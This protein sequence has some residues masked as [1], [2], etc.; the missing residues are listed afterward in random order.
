M[1]RST[2]VQEIDIPETARSQSL[3]RNAQL[4]RLIGGQALGQGG[5]GLLQVS[6]AQIVVFE[7]GKGATPS[8]VAKILAA[9]LLPYSLAGPVAGTAI[10][11]V[12]RRR[13]LT[14]TALARACL[15]VAALW[16][17][18]SRSQ[19]LGYLVLIA[20]LSTSRLVLAAKGAAIPNVAPP[21][22]LA[23]ANS[24][25]GIA[26]LLAAF[27]GALVGA[28]LA[29]ISTQIGLLA[30]G[31]VY[32]L[33]AVCFRGLGY[34]GG[35]RESVHSTSERA[36]RLR[37]ALRE[38]L[39]A[40]SDP[41]VG[42]ALAAIFANRFTMGAGLVIAVLVADKRYGLQAPGYALALVVTGVG[43][44][45]GTAASPAL[46]GK[47]S[48]WG[49][50][51][52]S[53]ATTAAAAAFAATTRIELLSTALF[54]AVAAFAFQVMK[55]RIDVHL[56][57]VAPDLVRGRVFSLYDVS[58]NLAFVIAALALALVWQ[59]ERENSLLWGVAAL[60]TTFALVAGSFSPLR[61]PLLKALAS[62]IAGSLPLLAF[63]EPSLWPI[64]WISL[65][66]SMVVVASSS[67]AKEAVW[68]SVWAGAGFFLA[69]HHWL[70]PKVGFFMAFI[71]ML[72]GAM[73]IPNGVTWWWARKKVRTTAGRVLVAGL[74]VPSV[75]TLLEF[76]R[77]WDRLGGAWGLMGATQWNS[78]PFL[79][80]A[81]LGGVWLL[82]FVVVAVNALVATSLLA[83]QGRAAGR[84]APLGVAAATAGA[85]AILGA[86]AGAQPQHADPMPTAP[87][88]IRVVGVQ[89]GHIEDGLE[90]FRA[91]EAI[92]LSLPS[93][94]PE[95]VDHTG[96]DAR[97]HARPDLI[98]W[99]ES[100][101][102]FDP[103][104]EPAFVE[105]VRQAA[106]ANGA[107]VLINV[108][109]R[110]GDTGG[111]Y[112]TA[113]VVTPEGPTS[114]YDKMRL[115]PFGEYVPLRPLLG[116][117]SRLTDAADE[118]R[119][120]GSSLQILEV[121][122]PK[123]EIRVGALVCFESSFPDMTRNLARSGAQLIVVQSATTTFQN[124][125][126]PEQHASLAA[127]RAAETG[128]PVVHATLSGHSAIYDSRGKPLV[129]LE[130]DR[131]GAYQATVILP[132]PSSRD[133]HATLYVRW[134]DWVV[135]VAVVV[136]AVWAAV[137]LRSRQPVKYAR[138]KEIYGA[139]PD[140]D[141]DGYV[142]RRG[143]IEERP[144]VR[145]GSEAPERHSVAEIAEITA[146]P[147]R[148]S[149]NPKGHQRR[150]A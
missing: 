50:A 109:A 136:V 14:L 22:R 32:G 83:S 45:L 27:L 10:D 75:W 49:T 67:T 60:G 78:Q 129:E 144:G 56:Q 59:P 7:I 118:D 142:C 96:D 150:N 61:R 92:T 107:S 134:G 89:P 110:R 122:T 138:R 105:W 127:L 113:L 43:A 94:N 80:L 63:P 133:A 74:V 140:P 48:T 124:S 128:L 111:I 77:C 15:A 44:A 3:A 38:E 141:T 104:K 2:Q 98:V 20:I 58:Y 23:E 99:G 24:A 119:R 30:A 51:G 86:V 147:N 47:R 102:G 121:P 123:E 117:L 103:Q 36:L 40:A 41:K 66:P 87:R 97:L 8:E 11:V 52:V 17:L 101:V 125:W 53:L 19:V 100:S 81:S 79:P 91:S 72:A 90:R 35:R 70:Y 76:V 149:A 1:D 64:A 31:A 42:G 68:R 71:A 126:A 95:G 112:K 120:R 34:L 54:L 146:N 114:S 29:G 115:V 131:T 137:S 4:L 18:L 9:S 28:G 73:W 69:V 12:D 13:L 143:R 139:S 39:N 82:S 88:A 62:G 26:G 5:D 145:V 93:N 65:V 33:S 21:E 57:E 25:S 132:P 108:D 148:W 46:A 55:I 6:L 135:V 116:W 85:A 130:T 84:I 16:V 106:E 37:L